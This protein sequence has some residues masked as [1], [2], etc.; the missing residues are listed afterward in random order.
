M[1]DAFLRTR[2][3]EDLLRK[4][5]YDNGASALHS[6]ARSGNPQTVDRLLRAGYNSMDRTEAGD[7][8]L[9]FATLDGNASVIETFLAN[10]A[11]IDGR[12]NIGESP[13]HTACREAHASICR[14]LLK[15]GAS[16]DKFTVPMNWSPLHSAAAGDRI[17][18]L[19]VLLEDADKSK[20]KAIMNKADMMGR[21]A[22][23]V[24]IEKNNLS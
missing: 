21:T 18:N 15:H 17:L 4:A 22:L 13:L 10:G 12:N 20:L 1:V 3:D 5:I 14:L 9:H 19:K 24:A 16:I 2:E 6:A 7:Q 23:H 11:N 8:C